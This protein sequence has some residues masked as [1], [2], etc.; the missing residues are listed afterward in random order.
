MAAK[1]QKGANSLRIRIPV[2]KNPYVIIPMILL[3]LFW[4]PSLA[5]FVSKSL[6]MN[7]FLIRIFWLSLLVITI[8]SGT[9]LL[10]ILFWMLFG[11]EEIYI[12]EQDFITMKPLVFY[13]RN[14]RYHTREIKDFRVDKESYKKM[15]NGEWKEDFRTIISFSVPEKQ[16]IFGRGIDMHDAELI[17]I[18]L[19]SSGFLTD[20]QF[21]T[22]HKS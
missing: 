9:A 20:Q 17:L 22:V 12:T 16:V 4:V 19:A 14:N 11:H 18:N 3:C 15:V 10:T 2:K 7:D 5:F 21:Y 6:L 1:I 8:A 13:V